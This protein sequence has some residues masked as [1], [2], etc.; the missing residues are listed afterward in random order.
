MGTQFVAG[1]ILAVGRTRTVRVGANVYRGVQ[2]RVRF[3]LQRTNY[4]AHYHGSLTPV[5]TDTV[6]LTETRTGWRTAKPSLSLDVALNGEALDPL[7]IRA[8]L[9][10]PER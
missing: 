4:P 10:P 6:W 7:R 8:A 9:Q 1:R 3:T 5:L 2:L